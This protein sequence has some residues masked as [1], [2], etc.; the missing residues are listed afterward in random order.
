MR[1]ELKALTEKTWK[2]TGKASQIN[3]SEVPR[4]A[5]IRND[6]D[7]YK[8]YSPGISYQSLGSRSFFSRA[9]TCAER[10]ARSV[11]KPRNFSRLRFENR[12]STRTF[13]ETGNRACSV[14]SVGITLV[15]I[16]VS[17]AKSGFL[18]QTLN[19]N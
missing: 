15:G 5:W 13:C 14:F 1:F 11:P 7:R 2:D 12:V 6:A 8:F 9:P 10:C 16:S 19:N 4:S 18:C 17:R 3:K